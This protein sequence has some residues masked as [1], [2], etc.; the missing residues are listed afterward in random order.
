[1]SHVYIY[2][3]VYVLLLYVLVCYMVAM[4]SQGCLLLS[5][6]FMLVINVRQQLLY[7]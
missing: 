2:F 4:C 7:I 3:I 1:M 5:R 6:L